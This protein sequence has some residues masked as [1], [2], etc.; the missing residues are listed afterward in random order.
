M[1]RDESGGPNLSEDAGLRL[2]LEAFAPESIARGVHGSIFINAAS[3][4]RCLE[5]AERRQ[6]RIKQ[7]RGVV[8]DLIAGAKIRRR[9][10]TPTE[11]INSDD[12]RRYEEEER[13]V[14]ERELAENS[15]YQSSQS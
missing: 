7:R 12:E 11:E 2:E 10:N 6:E 15:S 3:L 5:E 4:C 9:E 1:F 14:E 8:N 13:R